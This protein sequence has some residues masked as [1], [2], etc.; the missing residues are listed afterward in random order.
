MIKKLAAVMLASAM[1]VS[2]TAM[3]MSTGITGI[4]T[5]KGIIY[6]EQ[7]KNRMILNGYDENGVLRG[8]WLFTAGD[9]GIIIP[10]ELAEKYKLRAVFGGEEGIYDFEVAEGAPEATAEPETTTEPTAE[11]SAKPTEKPAKT[12]PSIYER[13]ID[14]V[15]AIAVVDK[16]SM[17]ENDNQEPYYYVDALYQGEEIRLGIEE[18]VTITSASDAFSYMN[19]QPVNA[20]KK[21]DVIC[22]TANLSGKIRNVGFVY[23]P[24]DKNIV[25]DGNDYGSS[26]EK[27]ISNNGRI[28]E[29]NNW[30]VMRYGGGSGSNSSLAFGVVQDKGGNSVTLLGPDGDISKAIVLAIKK[31]TIVY[32][33]DMSARKEL[34]VEGAGGIVKSVIPKSSENEQGIIT[35]SDDDDMSYALLRVVNGTVTDAVIY[36]NYNN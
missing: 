10:N 6:N 28:A 7:G 26:F 31:D 20:L 22:F 9:D 27:L 24:L 17:G 25:T 29:R 3:A 21:G 13:Q 19:G 16:V 33:C 35:Y 23:R 12:Y 8:S 18:D 2:S 15:D 11:P 36:T 1:A 34:S 30:A 4:S 5:D 14:A 32:V